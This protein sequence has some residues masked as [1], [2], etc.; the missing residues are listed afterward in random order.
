MFYFSL[1]ASRT[2]HV[3]ATIAIVT[4]FTVSTRAEDAPSLPHDWQPGYSGLG[5]YAGSRMADFSLGKFNLPRAPWPDKETWWEEVHQRRQS[6]QWKPD[7]FQVYFWGPEKHHGSPRPLADYIREFDFWLGEADGI[8]TYP[9]DLFAICLDEESA[10]WGGRHA[11]LDGLARHIRKTYG[12]KVYQFLSAPIRGEPRLTADGWILDIYE[13]TGDRLRRHLMS[14]KVLDKPVINIIWMTEPGLDGYYRDDHDA[15]LILE[16]ADDHFAFCREFDIAPALFACGIYNS[17]GHG[18]N[19]AWW[20]DRPA[21]NRMR[22][23]C[24]MKQREITATAPGQTPQSSANFSFGRT[25]PVGGDR[26]DHYAF[27]ETFEGPRFIDDADLTGFLEMRLTP[28]GT[29]ELKA[30]P[31]RAARCS[32]V[33]HFKSQHA[34]ADLSVEATCASPGSGR[35]RVAVSADGVTWHHEVTQENVADLAPLRLVAPTGD[36]WDNLKQVYIRILMEHPAGLDA[37]PNV[38]GAF[39]FSCTVAKP[40]R[41]EI[42]LRPRPKG[43]LHYVD[44]FQTSTW[45]H[46]ADESG[47]IDIVT[48]RPDTFG[49]RG[50]ARGATSWALRQKFILDRPMEHLA[51][52]LA[53]RADQRNLGGSVELG[54][55]LDGENIIAS[56]RSGNHIGPQQKTA[57]GHLVVSLDDLSDVTLPDVKAFYVHMTM[58]NTSGVDTNES[59]RIQQLQIIGETGA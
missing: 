53:Y 3:A 4:L 13:W 16:H 23:Y 47:D 44:D 27:E 40:V 28:R 58:R 7:I 43:D 42:I 57:A 5:F 29:L 52:R 14:F 2:T 50:A 35:N 22:K 8:E 48:W 1:S 20:S 19:N 15:S 38:L 33:Y 59:S 36:A 55:S 54:I 51:I 30:H 6:P 21:L 25:I 46:T 9:E 12:L 17:V 26:E 39:R 37:M 32:L 45:M 49:F 31:D 34:M 24:A 18:S 56:D 41:R 10:T 11:I